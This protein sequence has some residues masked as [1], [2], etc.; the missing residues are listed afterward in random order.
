MR[1][2]SIVGRPS[3]LE[4]AVEGSA[5]YAAAVCHALG[6]G[7]LDAV[8]ILMG[9]L[10]ATRRDGGERPDVRFERS[11]TLLYRVLFLLF[12]EARTLVPIAHPA[13]RDRYSLGVLVTELIGGASCR[14]LWQAVQAISRLAQNGCVAG[15]L[16][17]NAFN[18]QLFA[19]VDQAWSR[20]RLPD[21]AV[22]NAILAV[23]SQSTT[24]QQAKRG[25]RHGAVTAGRQPVL[26]RDL[27]VEQLGSIYEHALEHEPAPTA[28]AV[29][30]TRSREGRKASGTFYTPREMTDHVV[31]MTLAPLVDGRTASE[32]LSLKVLDPAMGS[33]AF[34]VATCRFLAARAEQALLQEG[35]WHQGDVTAADRTDLRRQIAV[36]CLYG[37]DLNPMAV[38]LARLSLWL[39]TL[40]ADRPLSFLDHHLVTGNSL[41][42]ATP[43]D[44]LRRPSKVEGRRE[45]VRPLP[46]FEDK[47]LAQALEHAVRTRIRLALRNDDSA[48]IV[49]QKERDLAALTGVSAPLGRWRDLF[50]LWCAGWFWPSNTPPSARL[51]GDVAGAILRGSATLKGLTARIVEQ[52]RR[53]AAEQ[54]FLHWPLTFPE[55]FQDE[56]GTPLPGGGFDAVLGNPPWDMIRGDSGA[57]EVRAARRAHARQ[58]ADFA[59]ES[60]VYAVETRA[61]VNTYQLFVE[62]AL[63]LLR[64]GGRLG[65]VLPSGIAS[66]AG[67]APLRRHL[68]DSADVDSITGFDNRAAIFPI[69]RSTRFA[70][71]TATKG[72]PTATVACRF[73]LTE[74]RRLEAPAG[75]PLVLSRALIASLSGADDLGIPELDSETD[76]RIWERIAARIPRLASPQGWH[77]TFGRE[78]NASDDRDKLRPATGRPGARPVVEGKQIGP[79]RVRLDECRFELHPKARI[80]THL[81]GRERVAYRD[82]ASAT[83][84]M[85]LIAAV[86]PAHAVSTHTLFCLRTPLPSWLQYALCALLNS[87]VANYLIRC[88]VNTHVTWALVARLP[89]PPVRAGDEQGIRLGHLAR[90]LADASADIEDSSEYAELQA[91]AAA[92]YGLTRNELGHVL[93]TFP[94]VDRDVRERVVRAF[95][96]LHPWAVRT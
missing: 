52:G 46:L 48:E 50:D 22:A 89:L 23:A 76:L 42:G 96:K 70:I 84:R 25:G 71:L 15:D 41:V 18:G 83:N 47:S 1:G 65:L 33:G 36:R 31:R 77:V 14:G 16:R 88:R 17:V 69:H 63:Q 82:V 40:A 80:P 85:T 87:F 73:G 28:P 26:Y 56:T 29:A 30:L 39:A 12:A 35:R 13:Y 64:R 8:G 68:L 19:S 5:R 38:Q 20:R 2:G 60:G 21:D 37:V 59:R 90:A 62:R 66:D 78:L 79:F 49:R 24:P 4:Q 9:S 11:L 27:D 10:P 92:S 58:L 34:L 67:T 54:R 61:H 93:E 55:V 86:L 57:E 6:R 75:A 81:G 44:V 95:R 43:A 45:R 91:L 32:I 53:V 3:P 94:L 51:F 7:V 74:V 72:S